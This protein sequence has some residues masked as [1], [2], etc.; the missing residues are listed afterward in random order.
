MKKNIRII[1]LCVLGFSLLISGCGTG[2]IFGPTPTPTA[3]STSTPTSTPTSTNT[4]Q[5]TNTPHATNTPE[6]PKCLTWDLIDK[7][8]EGK[9]ICFN[10]NVDK[11]YSTYAGGYYMQFRI[12]FSDKPNTF[13]LMDPSYQYPG[14]KKGDCVTAY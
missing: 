9:A 6:A 4:P 7:T 8:Y 11:A 2:Q 1:T 10:G 5:A 13:F 12:F 14:L 3:T